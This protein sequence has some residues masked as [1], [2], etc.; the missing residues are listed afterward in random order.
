MAWSTNYS[1]CRFSKYEK[2]MDTFGFSISKGMI[3]EDDSS[4]IILQ[5]PFL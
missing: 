5:N 1:R 4:K 2:I 3:A